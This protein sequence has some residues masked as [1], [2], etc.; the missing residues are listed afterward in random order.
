MSLKKTNKPISQDV[1][2]KSKDEVS[3]T[4][5]IVEQINKLSE[6]QKRIVVKQVVSQSYSGPIPHFTD[7]AGYENVLPGSADRIL[8]MAENQ[9]LHRQQLESSVISSDISNSRRGQ[10]FGFIIAITMIVGGLGL[11]FVGRNISG[12]G[13]MLLALGSL[14]GLF[15]YGKKDEAKEQKEKK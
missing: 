14:V 2:Q 7:F 5:Q 11:V 15:I 6:A 12:F 13:T 4:T 9:S 3:E 10:Y 8:L 1:K